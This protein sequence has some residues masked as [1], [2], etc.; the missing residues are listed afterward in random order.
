[1]TFL[2]GRHAMFGH[3]PPTYLRSIT[4]T[5]CPL[6]AKVQA[7]IVPPVP[8]PR[9]T[10]SYSSTLSVCPEG[11]FCVVLMPCS[12]G[13]SAAQSRLDSACE[14]VADHCRDFLR[15]SLEREVTRIEEMNLRIGNV[16]LEG[17]GTCWQEE[18][19]VL[20]PHCQEA[21]LVRS[22]VILEGWVHRNVAFVITEQIQL[23]FVSAGA[24]QIKVVERIAVGRNRG[25]FRDT[26]GVLP[27]CCLRFQKST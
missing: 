7:A 20:S 4:A 15:M 6:P 12:F 10:K 11:V 18:G 1:M 17:V 21:W 23:N 19:I 5:R 8:L 13:K 14:E 24:A 2:L 25:R 3:E 22:K 16:A 9:I 26:V 27:E